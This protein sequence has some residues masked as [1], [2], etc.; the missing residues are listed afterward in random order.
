MIVEKLVHQILKVRE[1]KTPL[2]IAIGG[3]AD[4]GKT[5]LSRA[6]VKQLNEKKSSSSHLPLDAYLMDR[7]ERKAKGLSGYQVEAHDME[8]IKEDLENWRN[9]GR[10]SYHPYEHENG[11]KS[12]QAV[13]IQSSEVLLIEGLFSMRKLLQPYINYSIFIFTTNEKLKKIKQEADLVKRSYSKEYSEQLY[14]KEFE[15]YKR[16]IEPFK[17]MA[18]CKVSLSTKWKYTWK[19]KAS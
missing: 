11:T 3:A 2:I 10:I 7:I 16:N 1:Q 12:K 4:L 18:D 15:L 9:H 14:E 13:S 17:N 19:E 6:I 8:L 5:H